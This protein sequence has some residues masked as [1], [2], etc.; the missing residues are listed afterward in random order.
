MVTTLVMCELQAFLFS[1]NTSDLAAI[2][3][4]GN[5]SLAMNVSYS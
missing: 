2:S 1:A 3:V 5:V 4:N